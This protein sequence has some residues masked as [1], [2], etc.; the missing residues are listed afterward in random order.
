MVRRC[1]AQMMKY[2][3]VQLPCLAESRKIS[4][5]VVQ[6]A[7][8]WKGRK[9]DDCIEITIKERSIRRVFADPSR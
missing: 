7:V 2:L 4:Q 8:Y 1:A 9:R 3:S 6:V 5:V